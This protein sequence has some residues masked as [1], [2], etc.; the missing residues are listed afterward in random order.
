MPGKNLTRD[1][2]GDRAGRLDVGAYTVELDLTG[3]GP[4]YT[5]TTVIGFSAAGEDETFVDLIA[6]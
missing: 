5:S 3:D 2:A 6:P 1:E 4:T